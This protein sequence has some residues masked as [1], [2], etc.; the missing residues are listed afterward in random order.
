MRPGG[1]QIRFTTRTGFAQVLITVNG[2]VV[3]SEEMIKAL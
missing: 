3:E 2:H 1:E